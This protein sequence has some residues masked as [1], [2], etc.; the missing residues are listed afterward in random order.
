MHWLELLLLPLS[1][2]ET[3]HKNL[4]FVV[5][6]RGGNGNNKN[7]PPFV[8]RVLMH[9]ARGSNGTERRLS[10]EE[11]FGRFRK[12]EHSN[13]DTPSQN[14]YWTGELDFIACPV[15]ASSIVMAFSLYLLG[16]SGSLAEP[17]YW[18]HGLTIGSENRSFWAKFLGT[19]SRV[20]GELTTQRVA[21]KK[22]P[23]QI[24]LSF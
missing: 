16:E 22:W 17:G 18:Y 2:F 1:P 7:P 23:L 9:L 12:V 24:I 5:L 11:I 19:I 15:R 13:V 14:L 10:F 4:R 6:P 3:C 21:K 20:N 8:L